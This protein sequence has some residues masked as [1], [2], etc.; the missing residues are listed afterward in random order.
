MQ[1]TLGRLGRARRR[2]AA[3]VASLFLLP[4]LF[5]MAAF[6]LYPVLHSFQLSLHNWSGFAKVSPAYIGFGNWRELMGDN[7]FWLSFGNNIRIVVLSI[8]IQ[9]PIGMG[10][11][12]MLDTG[13]RRLKPLKIAY[14]L[15]Y[16]MS[17]VAIGLL[18]R[19]AF[20]PYFGVVKVIMGL[21]GQ[22]TV[23]L[24]GHP[25]R[26]MYAVIGVICWQYIPFYM[27]YFLAGL[28]SLSA[29][30]YEAAII[31]GATRAQYFARIALPLLKPTIKNACILSLVGS[32]K[33]FDLIYV[34]TG[35]GPA[36]SRDGVVYGATELMATY[37]YKHAFVTNQM[38]YG[39]TVAMAMFLIV[40]CVSAVT[41]Y[42]MNR[43]EGSL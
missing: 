6:I 14:F 7:A 23:D 10:L 11:G 16:L 38:G 36:F 43:G 13:G 5:F 3:L 33:Y 28:S 22:G 29:D 41:L 18:F 31:D 4:A 30:V 17:S 2:E 9:L 27:V 32:L 21:L 12:F 8:L 15:P 26:V 1:G 40:T 19:Y 37:M 34:M 25:D 24:L 20:D 39:S 42:L 35:G